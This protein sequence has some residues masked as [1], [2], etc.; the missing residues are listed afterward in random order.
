MNNL[1]DKYYLKYLKYKK[2]YI[3][4]QN[5]KNVQTGAGVLSRIFSRNTTDDITKKNQAA[6]AAAAQAQVQTQAAEAVK[7]KALEAEAVK[8]AK[9]ADMEKAK[10]D[11]S[12][13]GKNSMDRDRFIYLLKEKKEYIAKEI[14]DNPNWVNTNSYKKMSDQITK[15][16][17]NIKLL[18]INKDIE[19]LET[20]LTKLDIQ[21]RMNADKLLK[22]LQDQ[23]YDLDNPKAALVK[24][25]EKRK[26]MLETQKSTLDIKQ[27]ELEKATYAYNESSNE[28]IKMTNLYKNKSKNPNIKNILEKYYIDKKFKEAGLKDITNVVKS[29]TE[30]LKIIEKGIA[31]QEA[32]LQ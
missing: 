17:E 7:T 16:T 13:I 14:K 6:S 30:K 2:K 27:K 32:V 10:K 3:D 12:S 28:Y 18:P 5:S 29:E 19:L 23:L 1:N 25:I 11:Y 4:L 20:L 21:T 26:N 15:Y 24:D 8:A 22:H 31:E 9:T